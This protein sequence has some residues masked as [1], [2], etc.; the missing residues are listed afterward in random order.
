[1]NPILL[2][3]PSE[4]Y[5]ER[6]HIRIPL[7]GDGRAVYEAIMVSLEELKPWMPFAHQEQTV[8]Q[9]EIGLREGHLKFLR[10]EDLRM[11]IFEK[12]TRQFIGSTGLHK[13]NWQVP[14]FEIGYWM[15]TRYSGKGYMT[16]AIQGVCDFGFNVLHARRIDILCDEMNTKSRAVPERLGFTLEGIMR[17]YGS[18]MDGQGLRNMCIYAMTK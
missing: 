11:L 5:T 17:N 16:E 15:D 10:R 12:D 1:M 7:P 6:L 2:D 3:F 9:V 14:K 13:P 4:F 18:T 8:E